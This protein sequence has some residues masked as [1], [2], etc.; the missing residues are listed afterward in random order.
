MPKII[1]AHGLNKA[2]TTYAYGIPVAYLANTPI[3]FPT[4][5]FD[6]LN[7]YNT[8]T[9]RYLVQPGEDGYYE[10]KA[11]V[12]NNNY[13][14]EV[15][16]SK[17]GAGTV[18]PNAVNLFAN[19]SGHTSGGGSAIIYA[20]TGDFLDIRQSVGSSSLAGCTVSFTKIGN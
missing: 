17:N 8:S 4:K 20:I 9:G 13:P 11:Y 5:A 3:I 19:A 16:V 18:G 12:S 2:K 1:D 10:I 15:Y 6:V 7:A 14:S